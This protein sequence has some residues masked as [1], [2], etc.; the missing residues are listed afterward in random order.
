MSSL[1]EITQ[2]LF[3]NRAPLELALNTMDFDIPEP[4]LYRYIMNRGGLDIT[5]AEL[6]QFLF[7]A[8]NK[9]QLFAYSPFPGIGTV[10]RLPTGWPLSVQHT[11]QRNAPPNPFYLQKFQQSLS[12]P[13]TQERLY[14]EFQEFRDVDFEVLRGILNPFIYPDDRIPA[15]QIDLVVHECARE[16]GGGGRLVALGPRGIARLRF[17][18]K[19]K[20]REQW[21][22]KFVREKMV[23]NEETMKEAENAERRRNQAEMETLMNELVGDEDDSL[24]NNVNLEDIERLEEDGM[25][26][27]CMESDLE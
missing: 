24:R 7:T 5:P 13:G 15:N 23:M 10:T 17:D 8:N 19:K 9:K 2:Y 6:R 16:S 1:D 3:A 27:T 20:D 22:T 25:E 21:L 26:L 4:T 18:V 14:A 11:I 12:D